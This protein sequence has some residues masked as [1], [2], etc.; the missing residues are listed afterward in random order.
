LVAIG[1]QPT[2]K[3]DQ[4]I[5]RTAVAGMLNLRNVLQLVKDTFNHS[6]LSQQQAITQRQQP[7]LHVS[8]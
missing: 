7:L 4:A 6:P 8:P 1:N 5:D 2:D 3:V